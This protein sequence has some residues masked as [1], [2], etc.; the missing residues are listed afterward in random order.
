MC[1]SNRVP[2]GRLSRGRKPADPAPAL[3]SGV[4]FGCLLLALAGGPVWA[5]PAIEPIDAEA[6][7]ARLPDQALGVQPRATSAEGLARQARTYLELARREG[8][9]RYLGYAQRTLQQWSD[10]DRPH[11]LRLLQATLDQ[12]LHRFD[13][14]LEELQAVLETTTSPALRAQAHLTRATIELVRG[15]YPAARDACSDLAR[16]RPG[17]M[18]ASCQ[19]QV[20]ARTGHADAAYQA[21]QRELDRSNPSRDRTAAAWTL[22]TLAD[23]AAQL[24]QPAA[25]DHWEQVLTLT[26]GDLYARTQYADWLLQHSRPD[27][28]LALTEGYD[29]VD[30]LAVLRAIALTQLERDDT[31]LVAHLRQRFAEAR[32]RGNLLH[33]RDYSR[34]LLDVENQPDDALQVARDNWQQQREPLDTRLL[35]RAARAADAADV[36]REVRDWLADNNQTD[37]RY[38][39]TTP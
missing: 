26:P 23:L 6:V 17:L 14:A 7:L 19:A 5:A 39:E 3:R 11:R 29:A 32:W 28:A 38:P 15:H 20:A 30:S 37:A 24:G 16:E 34:F 1:S 22:G 12:S 21:L 2:V 25:P 8:D 35:L 18:S 9:P 33:R 10:A 31:E 36:E 27:A 13:P 4:F